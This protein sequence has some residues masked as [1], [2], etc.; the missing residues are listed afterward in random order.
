MQ[1]EGFET[2][3]YVRFLCGVTEVFTEGVRSSLHLIGFDM[4]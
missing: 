1:H 3:I 4:V 2:F